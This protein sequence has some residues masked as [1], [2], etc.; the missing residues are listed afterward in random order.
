MPRLKRFLPLLLVVLLLLSFGG[1]VDS[2]Q[3]PSSSW[4]GENDEEAYELYADA[5]AAVY[6]AGD[7]MLHYTVDRQRQVYG[8]TFTEKVDGDMTVKNMHRDDM[9]AVVSER[10]LYGA[11]ETAYKEIFCDGKAYVQ[12][13]DSKFALNAGA[14]AY[15][16][17]QY[18]VVLIGS[19]YYEGIYTEKDAAGNTVIHFVEPV[20]MEPWL[21]SD[22][23]VQMQ[24]AAGT[25][26]IDPAGVLTETRYSITYVC[27]EVI[28]SEMITMQI[29][30]P[31]ELDVS[32][33]HPEHFENCPTIE[34]ADA[35]K[36]LLRSVGDVYSAAA[37]SCNVEEIIDSTAVPMRY[38]HK[39]N[40]S[41]SGAGEQFFAKAD[42]QVSLTDYRGIPTTTVRQDVFENGAY[43]SFTNGGDAVEDPSV[44]GQVMRGFVED[45]V[46]AAVFNPNHIGSIS[47]EVRDSHYYLTFQGNG[48]FVQDTMTMLNQFL[49]MD[50][51]AVSE[52]SETQES[53]GYLKVDRNTGLPVG[54]GIKLAR[55]HML[56]SVSYDLLYQ[57]DQTLNLLG[58]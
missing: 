36:L 21:R 11:L 33:I 51:D 23:R 37:I 4:D 18:P 30:L 50:L 10:L 38:V 41:L 54:M 47:L 45:A 53:S 32:G 49:Q 31:K 24:T 12:V 25:A 44:T 42:H 3:V 35:L 34:N 14:D 8:Q 6:S 26:I 48:V 16:A 52:M 15:L 55:K 43:T 20:V 56:N 19:D 7:L 58:K 29:K 5:C 27:G 46:L 1:C 57:L 13:N 39:S 28:Y 40:Y 22:S 2:Q 17:R 9:V